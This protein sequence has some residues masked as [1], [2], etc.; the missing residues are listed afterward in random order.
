M[1]VRAA[2]ESQWAD[3]AASS[4][5]FPAFLAPNEAGRPGNVATEQSIGIG[6][7]YKRGRPL[8]ASKGNYT[9]SILGIA[10]H[11]L[12]LAP[13]GIEPDILYWELSQACP[14]GRNTGYTGMTG[15]AREQ[16]EMI[17]LTKAG[18]R[19]RMWQS[20]QN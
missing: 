11:L 3:T 18:S 10:G 1:V 16:G 12:R 2:K 19:N 13:Y 5:G 20:G 4:P 7:S 17:T 15:Y 6:S 8:T 14:T 9:L